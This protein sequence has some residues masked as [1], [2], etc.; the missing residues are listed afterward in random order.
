MTVQTDFSEADL[1]E[2]LEEDE[3]KDTF[4]HAVICATLLRQVGNFLSDNNLGWVLDSTVEYRFSAWKTK[5]L[6]HCPDVSF[7]KQERLPKNLRTYP[8]IA[9]DLAIEV[10]SPD[11]KIYDIQAKVKLYQHLGVSLVWIGYPFDRT[12][13]IY[14]L[15]EGLLPQTVNEVG[16]LDGENVIPG[17]KLPL[18]EIFDYPP[19]PDKLDYAA[20]DTIDP[21]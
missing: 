7:I 21:I 4:E 11:D 2:E 17:F 19:S 12:V 16:I 3:S 15:S 20:D 14:R 18:S 1:P 10:I 5:T 8:E 13:A 9:P 6:G